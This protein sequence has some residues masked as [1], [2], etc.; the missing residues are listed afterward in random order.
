MKEYSEIATITVHS[1][2]IMVHL[3][4]DEKIVSLNL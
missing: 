2:V 1:A 3:L 4:L